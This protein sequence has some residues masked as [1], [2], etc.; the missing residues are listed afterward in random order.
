MAYETRF[1]LFSKIAALQKSID[2]TLDS[3][4]AFVTSPFSKQHAPLPAIESDLPQ[5]TRDTARLVLLGALQHTPVKQR[6]SWLEI[7]GLLGTLVTIGAFVLNFYMSKVS[8][9]V[10]GSLHPRNPLGTVFAITNEGIFSV[11]DIL[12]ACGHF[13]VVGN[14]F[15]IV[16][17]GNII[18]PES[19][20]KE[21]SPGHKM[22]LPCANAVGFTAPVNFRSAEMTIT[23]T[24]RPS[25]WPLN[26]T[27]VF[28]WKAE[29]TDTGE[30]IWKSVPR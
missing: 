10:E 15:S 30:W 24:F 14:G 21:L 28:P 22:T 29:R 26:K 23:A 3:F 2:R 11:N 16:G 25:F 7:L 13:N 9:S 18:F 20:A 6:K 12:V 4:W 5:R 19:R 27:E 17:P 8:V 1:S